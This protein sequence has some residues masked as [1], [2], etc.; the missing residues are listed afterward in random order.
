MKADT[1]NRDLDDPKYPAVAEPGKGYCFHWAD[2]RGV[3]GFRRKDTAKAWLGKGDREVVKWWYGEPVIGKGRSGGGKRFSVSDAKPSEVRESLDEDK[4]I[5]RADL[6]ALER[7]LDQM[8]AAAGIDIEF[9]KHFHD[10]VNDPRNVKQITID[11]LSGIFR[12]VWRMHAKRLSKAKVNW[13]AI[14]QDV[15]SDIHIPV[16]ID[17]NQYGELE[18]VSKT[19]MRK[20]G[21]TGKAQRLRVKSGVSE[22][23]HQH[24]QVDQI[25][26]EYVVSYPADMQPARTFEDHDEAVAFGEAE[27][28]SWNLG[29]VDASPDPYFPLPTDEGAH[30]DESVYGGN[31]F[32]SLTRSQMPQIPGEQLDAFLTYLRDEYGVRSR[33]TKKTAQDLSPFQRGINKAGVEAMRKR[34]GDAGRPMVVTSDGYV[35][36]GHHR[37]AQLKLDDPDR[38]ITVVEIAAPIRLV[39]A[40]AS[41]FTGTEYRTSE[42][43]MH[44]EHDMDEGVYDPYVLKAVFMAGG[45]GSGKGFIGEKMFG[46]MG[47]RVIN[48]DDALEAAMRKAGLDLKTQLGDERVQREGGIRDQAK[49]QTKRR[50]DLV[51]RGRLGIILDSTAT[52]PDKIVRQRDKLRALGYDTS[53]VFVNTSLDVAL[54]RNQ[55]REQVAPPQIVEKDWH[56][57]QRNI[58][59]FRTLFGSDNFVEI[60][61]DEVL[62]PREVT[63]RLVPRLHRAALRLINKPVQ[64]P[65][66]KAWIADQLA[67]KSRG[68]NR[69]TTTPVRQSS[70]TDPVPLAAS[71]AELAGFPLVETTT[72]QLPKSLGIPRSK[73]PQIQSDRVQGFLRHLRSLGVDVQTGEAKVRDLRPTQKHLN[74]DKVDSFADGALPDHKLRLPV[75]VSSDSRILDGHHRWAALHQRDPENTIKVHRVAVP[76]RRLLELAR[77]YSGATTKNLRE[78]MTLSELVEAGL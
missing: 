26:G 14:I 47:L 11:E 3:C 45:G 73:M 36:D 52:K 28:A 56:R 21:F 39:I 76:M 48:S 58:A 27:A 59:K 35:L 17:M 12:E 29:F 69:D 62:M 37:W 32:G 4:K 19:V 1:I 68:G 38:Q 78:S 65:V 64:N 70:D 31:T 15:T 8:F 77:R 72:M 75:I 44:E 25:G 2:G 34:K 42:S 67:Q 43:D 57:V 49:A 20:R 71:V 53:M 60:P 46:G 51:L 40:A 41:E 55:M 30:I 5:S 18:L 13:P 66:G 54:E 16:V 74:Q 22:H 7:V 9:T 24:V 6:A 33:R 10:R 50:L 61:N 23:E 63:A